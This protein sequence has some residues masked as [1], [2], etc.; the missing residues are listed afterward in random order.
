MLWV[1]KYVIGAIIQNDYTGHIDWQAL[2]SLYYYQPGGS[3]TK[4]LIHW[5]QFI[6]GQIPKHFD[7]GKRIN[8]IKYNSPEPPAYNY[9][10]L[11]EMKIDMFITTS[12]GDPYCLEEDFKRML[13]TFKKAKI[14]VQNAGNYNHL[15]YLWGKSAH[16]DIYQHIL[17]FLQDQ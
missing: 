15:D 8:M 16:A 4:N 11:N 1:C 2:S 17:K 6:D 13:E 3:S 5:L 10:I 7:Y 9:E 12:S 14:T